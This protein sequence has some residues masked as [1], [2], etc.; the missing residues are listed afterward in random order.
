MF[1]R[2]CVRTVCKVCVMG[3]ECMYLCKREEEEGE[4][5]RGGGR[6]RV[7]EGAGGRRFNRA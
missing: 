5:D 2:V 4:R 3:V 6:S 7:E 1:A